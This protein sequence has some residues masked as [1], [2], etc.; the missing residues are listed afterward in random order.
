[1][2]KLLVFLL[3][4]TI[5][6]SAFMN[7]ASGQTE[8]LQRATQHKYGHIIKLV[9]GNSIKGSIVRFDSQQVVFQRPG[10]NRSVYKI[11]MY[12][13]KSIKIQSNGTS[14]RGF[15]LG[16]IAGGLLGGMIAHASY[17]EHTPC[18]CFDNISS[19]TG[20]VIIGAFGGVLV[21]GITGAIIG[22]QT[23]VK[24]FRINGDP[25]AFE[26]ARIA[27]KEFQNQK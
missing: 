17:E 3:T 25:M 14:G 10:R 22:S 23:S 27:F 5:L 6:L 2:K 26:R 1:M 8:I 19:K 7:A 4:P 20:D 21:G 13:I 16:T 15:F 11:N 12:G 24:K 18:N 9:N